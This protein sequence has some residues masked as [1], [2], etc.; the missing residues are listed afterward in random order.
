MAEELR[1]FLRT[2]LFAGLIA[3]IYWFVSYE[4]AGTVLLGG[5]AAGAAVFITAIAKLAPEALGDIVDGEASGGG[6][7]V[8][9]LKRVVGFEEE[10]EPVRSAP[11]EIAEEPV[12]HSSAWPILTALAALLSGLGLLFG[13]WFWLPGIVV[14]AMSTWGWSSQLS[15]RP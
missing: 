14:A 12:A 15:R 3:L 4:I 5:L 11:L 10:S 6:K 9:A 8:T 7:L 1:F 2:G 13:A